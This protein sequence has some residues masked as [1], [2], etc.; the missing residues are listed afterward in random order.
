MSKK[1]SKKFVLHIGRAQYNYKLIESDNGDSSIQPRDSEDRG[2]LDRLR[3]AIRRKP[4]ELKK[5]LLKKTVTA[6]GQGRN[7]ADC[8]IKVIFSA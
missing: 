1:K 4:I 6:A 8:D 5:E 7:F 3:S 2:F